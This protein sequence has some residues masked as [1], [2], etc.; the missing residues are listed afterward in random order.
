M[1]MMPLFVA[2]AAACLF[3][4]GALAIGNRTCVDEHEDPPGGFV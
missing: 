2:L 1:K 4:V 3:I